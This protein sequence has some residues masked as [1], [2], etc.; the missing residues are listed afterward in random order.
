MIEL[1]NML[2]SLLYIVFGFVSFGIFWFIFLKPKNKDNQD[3]SQDKINL[4]TKEAEVIAGEKANQ[5]LKNQLKEK[6]E[7]INKLYKSLD[8]VGEYKKLTEVAINKHDT[9]IIR[10]TAWWE[11]LTSNIQYQG[12]FNQQILENVLKDAQLV[13]DRDFI[14]QKQQTTYDVGEDKDK[15][16]SPDVIITFPDRNYV[17]D[18]KVSLA[19]W[20]KYILEPKENKEV[21]AKYLKKHIDS[22]RDH[23]FHPKKGLIKKNYHKLYNLKTFQAV[24]VFFPADALFADSVDDELFMDAWKANFLLTSPKGLMNLIKALEQIKSEKKQIDNIDKIIE[25]A[26][27]IFDKYADV[28]SAM[29]GVIKTYREHGNHL[30]TVVTKSWGS[31]GLEKQIN[32]LK[33]DHGVIPGKPIPEIP[34]EQTTIINVEDS[35]EEDKVINLDSEKKN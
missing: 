29:K 21:K 9:T 8:D 7:T 10:Q 19:S 30:Q 18:A 20:T 3:N 11:K 32:K 12:K 14:V 17:V 28:K 22:V 4:A 31:K 23:L 2:E 26:R 16:V 35:E 25:S 1:I 24:I 27:K 33:D 13:R 5:E 6:T 15:N 34:Q